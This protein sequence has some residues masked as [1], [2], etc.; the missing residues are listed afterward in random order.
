MFEPIRGFTSL[1]RTPQSD[2]KLGS[3]LAFVAGAINAGG[4]LAVGQYTSH[5]TGIVSSVADNLVLGQA[6]LALSGLIALLAF[7]LGAMCT[8]WLVN[9]GMRLALRSAYGLPLML[10]ALLLLVF[11]LFGAALDLLQALLVPLT[12]MLLCFI[13]GLQNAVI[14]KISQARIRTTHVT[15]LVTDL[16]I[17]LGR[18]LFVNRRPG[19]QP[20]L[21]DRQ[22]LRVHLQL[23][24]C[25]LGGGVAG[26]LGFK[27]M[28]YLSAVP[29]AALFLLL[30][31]RPALD[32][33]KRLRGL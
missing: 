32:D 22:R 4:L 8:T 17:E 10:E 2:L 28:G 31:L 30:V 14:T 26:A 16:G 20:V 3:V 6:W 12:V 18:L 5:M 9:W 7:L 19:V 13:M 15:G 23:V 27:H 33:C 1:Q 29:L 25:F 21:A 24:C 11:G